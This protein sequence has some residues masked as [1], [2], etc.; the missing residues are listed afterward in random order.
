MRN[1]F[2]LLPKSNVFFFHVTLYLFRRRR[3]FDRSVQ[4][5]G[6]ALVLHS[7]TD[8]GPSRVSLH[9]EPWVRAPSETDAIR[10]LLFL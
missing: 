10:E 5:G 4:T 6:R 8:P 2:Q 1:R 9:C 7:R 3:S